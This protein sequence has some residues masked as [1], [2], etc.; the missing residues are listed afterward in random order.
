MGDLRYV[1][2]SIKAQVL[3]LA[4]R[5]HAAAVETLDLARQFRME[6]LQVEPTA[7][8]AIIDA[9]L[10]RTE[11]DVEGALRLLRDVSNPDAHSVLFAILNKAH[12]DAPSVEWYESQDGREDPSFFTGRGW[13]DLAVAL[14]HLER[15]DEASSRLVNAAEH[16][17]G[18]PD[19][20]YIE[21]VV[22]AALLLPA[23]YRHLSLV[24]NLF[25]PVSLEGSDADQRRDFALTCFK[26]AE[27]ALGVVQPERAFAAR[28]WSLWLRLT[29]A[30]PEERKKT[31]AELDKDLQDMG[32]AIPLVPLVHLFNVPYDADRVWK[33]LDLRAKIGGL[34]DRELHA[35]YV[36]AQERLGP[37][38]FL[39]FLNDEE[40][41]LGQLFPRA[42][43]AV[44][45][46][47]ALVQ[48]GQTAK[49]RSVLAEYQAELKE[50]EYRRISVNLDA[51]EGK[52]PR[53]ELERLYESTHSLLDLQ[54]LVEHLGSVKD[55]SALR[56]LLFDLFT[57]KQ[58][59]L[60]NLKRLVMCIEHT[61]VGSDQEILNLLESNPDLA[62]SDPD[63]IA[64]R[65]RVLFHLGR[66]GEA[67]GLND[68][69]LNERNHPADLDLDIK[70]AL[71]LG[72]WERF[73]GIVEREWLRRAEH[74][75]RDLIRLAALA[76]EA[77]ATASR[78]F[79]L[80][81]LAAE[82]GS[83]DPYILEPLTKPGLVLSFDAI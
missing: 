77:D 35:R 82:K 8:T 69:L 48:G 18:H 7:D 33:Y 74:Q 10:L 25:P 21:G 4:A 6:L 67:R 45:K 78:A 19:F 81:K 61:S 42:R 65:A 55:W 37:D 11:G 59:T 26:R 53:V 15:W 17:N 24:T 3:Q 66:I 62:Q 31:V 70:L 71:Q 79:E 47:G 28:E 60:R 9:L 22:N 72:D 39:L 46:I 83:E 76:A 58:R 13:C 64:T 34:D 36:L 41:R 38:G 49:A 73:P 56:P 63:L 68:K 54:N 14:A 32:K 50:E 30:D 52:D 75:A 43:I 57:Q 1:S 12:G 27:D 51:Q 23:E 40:A 5:L 80:L 29:H 44:D 2:P 20:S 16:R